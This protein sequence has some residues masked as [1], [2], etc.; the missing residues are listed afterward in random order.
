MIRT[1][2][3]GTCTDAGAAVDL[4]HQIVENARFSAAPHHLSDTDQMMLF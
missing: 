3:F 2:V 1:V 4:V